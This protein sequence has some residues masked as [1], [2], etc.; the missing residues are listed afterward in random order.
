MIGRG[1][2][3]SNNRH[4]LGKGLKTCV[5]NLTV[6]K[7]SGKIGCVF[8][9]HTNAC[10]RKRGR[11]GGCTHSYGVIGS[12]GM[13]AKGSVIYNFSSI[14]EIFQSQKDIHCMHA[15]DR[16]PNLLLL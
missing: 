9:I 7:Q 10:E 11:V 5:L 3:G 2:K 16:T 6:D 15:G 4:C 13:E 12:P 14:S 8:S 1:G